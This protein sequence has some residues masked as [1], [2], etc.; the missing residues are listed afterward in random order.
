MFYKCNVLASFLVL[1]NKQ[2]EKNK[3]F[4]VIMA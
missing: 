1:L 4:L 3:I 2:K